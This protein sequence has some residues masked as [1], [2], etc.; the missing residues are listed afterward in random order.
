VAP[1]RSSVVA[2][3]QDRATS[4]D[5]RSPF[6]GAEAWTATVPPKTGNPQLA[7]SAGSESH[8]EQGF[9]DTRRIAVGHELPA[10]YN[11]DLSEGVAMSDQSWQVRWEPQKK[12]P[13]S[14]QG[15]TLLVRSKESPHHL[16]VV[17]A[18]LQQKKRDDK[19]R[20]R[21]NLE[22]AALQAVTET[23]A[24]VPKVLESNTHRFADQA[25]DLYFVM[26]YIPGDA[27]SKI[28]SAKGRLSPEVAIPLAIDLCETMKACHSKAVMHRD[29]KPDNIIVR[30]LEKADLVVVDYGLSFNEA[31]RQAT[32]L[33]SADEG[34]GNAFSDLP[35]RRTPSAQRRYESDLTGV[36]GV[37]YYCLTGQWPRPFR[38]AHNKPPHR[39]EEAGKA[40][41]RVLH[42]YPAL[43]KLESILDQGFEN[44]IGNR[45]STADQL[46]QRLRDLFTSQ[47][48]VA[49][50]KVDD[51]FKDG[52]E[53]LFKASRQAQLAKFREVA[54]GAI[55]VI[56]QSA[57]N[58]VQNSEF[59][60]FLRIH[61]QEE[62]L[63]S[64][65]D[66]LGIGGTVVVQAI[67]LGESRD[68]QYSFGVQG[69]QGVLL[70]RRMS[71]KSGAPRSTVTALRS[72]FGGGFG[73]VSETTLQPI[74]EWLPRVW[75]PADEG[76]NADDVRAEIEADIDW[77]V[78]E[79]IEFL[80]D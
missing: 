47:S 36:C 32:E 5:R 69:N 37:L 6:S 63:P 58:Q 22:V 42:N 8:A 13:A 45:F 61:E 34:I 74:E 35:E 25:I 44:D 23:A 57:G 11:S 65:I 75:F 1:G 76:P 28:I 43:R 56:Q 29:I 16:A 70:R 49:R 68:A 9:T 77:A 53:R 78:E 20:R 46:L 60:S 73:V 48:A 54:R 62:S 19:A 2:W 27:L 51:I 72:G 21:M 66:S 64:G 33:T 52:S 4:V 17:K 10:G 31:A 50:R 79:I 41:S 59:L 71:K 38:D 30:N 55:E 26:E 80:R 15:E 67:K 40:T 14:G 3:P 12:L 7:V 39:S 18:L 24:K